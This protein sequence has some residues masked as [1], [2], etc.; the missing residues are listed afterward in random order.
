MMKPYLQPRGSDLIIEILVKPQAKNSKILG[1]HGDRLKIAIA[2]IADK[3][4]ANE[5]LIAFLAECLQKPKAH[6][7]ILTGHTSKQKR[8]LIIDCTE[9]SFLKILETI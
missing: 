3:G 8:L 2:E 9:E 6:I 5:E 4:K 7:S 1:T